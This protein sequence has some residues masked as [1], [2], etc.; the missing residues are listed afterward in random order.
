MILGGVQKDF[1]G[2]WD[3]VRWVWFEIFFVFLPCLGNVIQIPLR[4][5][6]TNGI[7]T[8][9][10]H[11]NHHDYLLF[12]GLVGWSFVTK[13]Q[14]KYLLHNLFQQLL[15]AY[16]LLWG[17]WKIMEWCQIKIEESYDLWSHPLL[18]QG[19]WSNTPRLEHT[20]TNCLLENRGHYITN[21]NFMHEKFL[22]E[23]PQ[24]YHICVWSL[25]PQQ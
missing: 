16:F 20:A 23:F 1:G 4:I 12:G 21:P 11:A 5:H 17:F 25:I 18:K 9:I 13:A 19:V 22:W 6:G 15:V 14:E 7:F 10:Y 8:Y 3:S 24:I 2:F